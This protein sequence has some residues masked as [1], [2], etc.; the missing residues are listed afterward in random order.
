MEERNRTYTVV[1]IVA[2]VALVL[3]CVIG[4][5]AGAATGF[6]VARRQARLV[7]EE[8]LGQNRFGIPL[9]ERALPSLPEFEGESRPFF[10]RLPL[11]REGALVTDVV[12]GTPADEAG[13]QPGDLILSID[14]TSIDAREP[15][16]DV[17]GQ[18]EPGDRITITFWRMGTEET[19]RVR[20]GTHP[21]DPDSAYLG[22][23]YQMVD[24]GDFE[25]PQD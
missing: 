5:L 1:A 6:V 16:S 7:A 3:S 8:S 25:V 13:L 9:P 17:I 23:F 12:S 15:L 11:G 14:G 19:V 22:I 18:Y 10:D 21:D 20:L 24:A 2:I 4:A